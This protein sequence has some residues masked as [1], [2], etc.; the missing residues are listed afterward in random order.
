MASGITGN[1]NKRT[2][3]LTVNFRNGT[4]NLQQ[5]PPGVAKGF[6]V[7]KSKGTFF[8]TYLKGKY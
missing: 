3:V 7:A 1:Y 2:R 8:N 4:W 6:R 5:V